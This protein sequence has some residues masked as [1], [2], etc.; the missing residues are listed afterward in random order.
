MPNGLKMLWNGQTAD[1]KFDGKWYPWIGDPGHTY[2]SMKRI[3]PDT[4]EETDKR[5]GKVV[6]VSRY[7]LSADGETITVVD[8]DPIHETQTEYIM[9]KQH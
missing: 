6:D 1:V 9:K 2:L 3:A 4:L 5:Q 7:V 8:K